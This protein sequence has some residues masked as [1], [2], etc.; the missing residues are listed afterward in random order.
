MRN[1]TNTTSELLKTLEEVSRTLYRA[2][3][4]IEAQSARIAW[5]ENQWKETKALMRGRVDS[6]SGI[7]HA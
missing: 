3:K 4:T 1:D 5:L 2:R 7:P 6:K